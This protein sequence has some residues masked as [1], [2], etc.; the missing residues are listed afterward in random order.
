MT[1][2]KLLEHIAEFD[3]PLNT[4]IFLR[5]ENGHL[6]Q[7][8]GT[9]TNNPEAIAEYRRDES[10]SY[11]IFRPRRQRIKDGTADVVA[12]EA[13]AK[14]SMHTMK[15]HGMDVA[16]VEA[17]VA[18]ELEKHLDNTVVFDM[19]E[20]EALGKA[21]MVLGCATTNEH[22]HDEVLKHVEDALGYLQKLIKEV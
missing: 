17:E 16:G 13:V 22:T 14:D 1:L 15:Y 2:R 4:E 21:V 9:E 18:K 19:D 10:G 12:K 3:I 6:H 8:G 11:I 20:L 7:V 5:D